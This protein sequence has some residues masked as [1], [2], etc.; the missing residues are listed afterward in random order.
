MFSQARKC[1]DVVKIIL[2]FYS[3][4]KKGNRAK[5]QYLNILLVPPEGIHYSIS[6]KCTGS[7][8]NL[9]HHIL[10]KPQYS[11]LFSQRSQNGILNHLVNILLW[12]HPIYQ[13]SI[14]LRTKAQMSICNTLLWL[15]NH[16]Y[17][18]MEPS[19]VLYYN[20]YTTIYP[21]FCHL[22]KKRKVSPL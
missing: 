1:N 3:I 7:L 13:F 22:L 20:H 17:I 14:K 6:P 10:P 2:A 15:T 18:Q 4:F 16:R 9:C 21:P 5:H 19:I 8:R 11:T 12:Y